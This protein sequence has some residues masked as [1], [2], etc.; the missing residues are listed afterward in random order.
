MKTSLLKYLTTASLAVFTMASYA[1]AQPTTTVLPDTPPNFIG[2]AAKGTN[3]ITGPDPLVYDSDP[4]FVSEGYDP[5]PK[6]N[7]ENVDPYDLGAA[8]DYFYS[9]GVIDFQVSDL[10]LIE[11]L[12][13]PFSSFGGT[14]FAI[15]G[16]GDIREFQYTGLS[17]PV[18]YTVKD[19]NAFTIFEYIS[20]ESNV[21]YPPT[22]DN[23]QFENISHLSV[24]SATT[25]GGGPNP[26][27]PPVT[28]VPET[29]TVLLSLMGVGSL[30]FFRRR[31]ARA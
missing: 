13:D 18:F 1:V 19:A 23:G 31:R 25:I 7:N 12:D 4:W 29:S 14:N 24:W 6:F 8:F 22:K 3:P 5:L 9:D 2:T 10:Q 26:A 11:K 21:L 27:P 15:T 28:A 16:T 17:V 30:F 20:D